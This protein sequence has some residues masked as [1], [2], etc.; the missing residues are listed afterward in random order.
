MNGLKT[1][2]V[3]HRLA[4]VFVVLGIAALSFV[5]TP[6]PAQAPTPALPGKSSQTA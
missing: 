3:V 4:L 5:L 6:A 2:R 1:K